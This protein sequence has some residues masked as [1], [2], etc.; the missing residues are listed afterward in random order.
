MK[1]ETSRAITV[2]VVLATT[3]RRRLLTVRH[4]GTASIPSLSL[5]L[6]GPGGS[7]PAK[8][9]VS[10]VMSSVLHSWAA[11]SEGGRA[12]TTD[13]ASERPYV[14]LFDYAALRPLQAT[15]GINP[16]QCLLLFTP[17]ALS[18]ALEELLAGKGA[19][20]ATN[21]QAAEEERW[22]GLRQAILAL[23][24]PLQLHRESMDKEM[25][26]CTLKVRGTE[27]Q[28]SA[29]KEGIADALGRAERVK[30]FYD[31]DVSLVELVDVEAISLIVCQGEEKLS[32]AAQLLED[33]R[34]MV[35][36]I[37]SEIAKEEQAARDL[38]G[39]RAWGCAPASGVEDMCESAVAVLMREVERKTCAVRRVL[40]A[41]RK[42]MRLL[43]RC[44]H[45]C[46]AVLIHVV[47]R[48]R[49][50]CDLPEG[51]EAAR[52]LVGRR[53]VLRR[54]I[55]RLLLPLQGERDS[56]EDA[57][58]AFS[59]RWA[60]CVPESIFKAVCNPLPPLLPAEDQLAQEMDRHLVDVER[61]VTEDLLGSIGS[62]PI[63]HSLDQRLQ[64]MES[65]LQQC[66]AELECT[67]QENKQLKA[68]LAT[69]LKRTEVHGAVA[70][71]EG[72]QH[73]G[74]P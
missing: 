15:E 25:E 38:L 57:V 60:T 42:V 72:G 64:G 46:D 50:L 40:T 12:S 4:R 47:Q 26:A 55:R 5:P 9:L 2:Q 39:T 19:A 54:A 37:M 32:E 65:K 51:M 3:G 58:S 43:Q 16:G 49:N 44:D 48:H 36:D 18:G 53:I 61:D 69:A 33:A 1:E 34:A 14:E 22:A 63:V 45:Y 62:T 56:I 30:V 67:R 10:D 27:V 71:A 59:Q 70:Q 6:P 20:D 23:D 52:E 24:V 35:P 17:A 7:S 66:M 73:K 31:D 41:I 11:G 21:P 74:M 68:A 13:T 29:A 8:V 28:F